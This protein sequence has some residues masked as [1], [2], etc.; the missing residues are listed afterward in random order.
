M[1]RRLVRSQRRLAELD[2]VFEA[3][4]RFVPVGTQEVPIRVGQHLRRTDAEPAI[5][6]Q[7][8]P[9]PP[10]FEV[11]QPLDYLPIGGE[12]PAEGDER[13]SMPEWV[14][15]VWSQFLFLSRTGFS[16]SGPEKH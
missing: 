6:H 3:A 9:H 11:Q 4:P 2:G 5:L 8:E 1:P 7:L 10:S 13:A 12:A 14:V 16:K 15:R